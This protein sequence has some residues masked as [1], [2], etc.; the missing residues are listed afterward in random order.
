MCAR[1]CL[2]TRTSVCMR[3]YDNIPNMFCWV[4][5][6][7]IVSYFGGDSVRGIMSGSSVWE[8]LSREFYQVTFF[9][10]NKMVKKI[11]IYL[12]TFSCGLPNVIYIYNI[13][14]YIYIYIYITHTDIREPTIAV[15]ENA[16]RCIPSKNL[17]SLLGRFFHQIFR[18]SEYFNGLC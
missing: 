4:G 15:G 9:M 7:W 16:T 8:I 11:R 10:T 18:V 3:T 13:Y 12:K 14:I 2:K 1:M 6:L 17:C 5:M